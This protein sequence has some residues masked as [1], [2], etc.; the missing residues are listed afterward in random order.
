MDHEQERSEGTPRAWESV[1][2]TPTWDE[3]CR[4]LRDRG[5][6]PEF[7]ARLPDDEDD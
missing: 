3:I 1:G 2:A 5:W 7:G 4:V 6:L